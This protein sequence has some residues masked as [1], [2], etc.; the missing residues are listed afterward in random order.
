MRGD[1]YER[2][3]SRRIQRLSPLRRLRTL[4][5]PWLRALS[6]YLFESGD[7]NELT[8][9]FQPVPFNSLDRF[10]SS[11]SS[12]QRPP[13]DYQHRAGSIGRDGNELAPPGNSE[14]SAQY[15]EASRSRLFQSQDPHKTSQSRR[16]KDATDDETLEAKLRRMHRGDHKFL[17]D[18][19]NQAVR[20]VAAQ[21]G[22]EPR[23]K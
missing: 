13:Y 4:N 2:T 6:M 5:L 20:V 11:P 16:K 1:S 12:S 8:V 22:S 19:H 17:A 7:K 18:A 15:L 23:R 10:K 21:S 14:S 9:S 3:S